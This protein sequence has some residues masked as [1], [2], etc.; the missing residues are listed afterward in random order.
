MRISLKFGTRDFWL[1][2]SIFHILFLLAYAWI[3]CAAEFFFLFSALFGCQNV[4]L[5]GG[6]IAAAMEFI[7]VIESK[8][9]F[10]I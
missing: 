10:V 1:S 9:R 7:G 3:V 5:D 6:P 4:F 8:E 2:I